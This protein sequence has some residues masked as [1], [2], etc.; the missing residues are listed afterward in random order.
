MHHIVDTCVGTSWTLGPG[1]FAMGLARYVVEAV[2]VEGRSY[3]E[4]AAAHGVSKSW[5]A[6]VV[7]RLRE[8]GYE[9]LASRLRAPRHIP[10]RRPIEVE[11]R[12]VAIRNEPVSAGHDAGAGNR[13]IGRGR[14]EHP[15]APRVVGV[16]GHH[17]AGLRRLS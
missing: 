9:A 1:V 17:I 13:G 10:H 12:I 5:V 8:G 14:G 7:G 3:R 6:K 16:S 15:L 4:A 2:L 11:E